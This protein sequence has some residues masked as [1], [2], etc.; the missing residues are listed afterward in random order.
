MNTMKVTLYFRYK[1]LKVH[2]SVFLLRS[3]TDRSCLLH[4][5]RASICE[6]EET[7]NS[8]YSGI[9]NSFYTG[10]ALQICQSSSSAPVRYMVGSLRRMISTCRIRT[11]LFGP[12]LVGEIEE[13]RKS[14]PIRY[15]NVN[16]PGAT[17]SKHTGGYQQ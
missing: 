17:A 4:L 13:R 3:L 14:T 2:S 12:N 1:S 10:E 6:L 9:C 5:L 15:L 16:L 8:A 7:G 11:R